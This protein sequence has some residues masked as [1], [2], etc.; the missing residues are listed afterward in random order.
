VFLP[1]RAYAKINLGLYVQARR[2]DGYHDICTVFHRI[3]LCDEIRFERSDGIEVVSSSPEAPGDESNL[4]FKAA[5]ALQEY[6]VRQQGVRIH[7]AK[8][9][10]VGAGLGGGSSDAAAVLKMLPGFWRMTVADRVLSELA[11]RIG[12]DVPY[13]L[14]HGSAIATGRGEIL[15]YF[16]LNLPFTILVCHPAIHIS[17]TW[18][19]GAMKPSGRRPP[20]IRALLIRGMENPACLRDELQNDFEDAIVKRFPGIGEI[21]H[22][23]TRGGAVYASLSGSGS[24]VYGLFPDPGQAATVAGQFEAQGYRTWTTPPHFHPAMG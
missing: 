21:K 16:S 19:Y 22:V 8:Q 9:I 24:A 13:F 20:D 7:L 5:R 23:M 6:E 3:D 17:T 14:G 1:F 2:A 11:A 12:S 10:P 4:C 18:A 15:E